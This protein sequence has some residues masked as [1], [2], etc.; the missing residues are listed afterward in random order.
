RTLML[1]SN[2]VL[3]A[4]NGDPS[5][6]PSQEIVLVLYYA[7]RE[8]INGTGEGLSFTGVSEVIRAELHMEVALA[9]RVTV[10]IPEMVRQEETSA[11]APQ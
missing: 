2:T 6:V 1:A 8:A 5:S 3:F 4:S 10:R 7:T 9:S 11:G